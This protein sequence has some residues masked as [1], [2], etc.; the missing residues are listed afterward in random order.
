MKD[1]LKI[2]LVGAG[3]REFGPASIRDLLLSDPLCE[4]GLSIVLVDVDPSELPRTRV[5]AES[6]ADRLGRRVL[7]ST[8]SDLDRAFPGAHAVVMAIELRR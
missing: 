3:S 4:R 7:V 1:R 2:V 5:Y 8:T 6:V